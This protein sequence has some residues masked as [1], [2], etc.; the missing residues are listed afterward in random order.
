MTNKELIERAEAYLLKKSANGYVVGKPDSPQI[1][2]SE[3]LKALRP[4]IEAVERVAEAIYN[5]NRCAVDGIFNGQM[6]RNV[7]LSFADVKRR[8]PEVYKEA[9]EQAKAAIQAMQQGE[10]K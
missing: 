2:I 1:L 10:D 6:Q 4:D 3:L 9:I 8:M 5:T 7:L